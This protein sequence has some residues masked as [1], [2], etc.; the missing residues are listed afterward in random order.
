MVTKLVAPSLTHR[1][2]VCLATQ[3][4]LKPYAIMNLVRSL[5]AYSFYMIVLLAAFPWRLSAQA[6]KY[7]GMTVVNIRFEPQQQP[8]EG[9]ELF[10]I[11]PL[12]RGEPLR[13][14][15]V[16]AS[17]ERLFATGRYADIK[18]A[19]EPYNGGG[20]IVTFITTNS[21]FIGDVSVSGRV[22]DPPNRGQLVNATR[23]DLGE[24]YTGNALD[25]AIAAQK[26]LLE[27]NGL[28]LSSVSPTFDYD[29]EHQLINIRFRIDSG[30][31]ARFYRPV[32]L[33]NYKLDPARILTATRFRRW[34]IHTWKPVTQTRMRQGLDGVRSLYQK[35]NRLEAKVQL[36]SV[37]FDPATMRLVPTLNIDA[38][39]RI[40]VSTVGAK[41]SQ[42]KL[43]R[44]VP[45]FEEH[46]VDQDLLLEGAR[47]LRDYYQSQ[48]YFEAQ[49][50]VVPQKVV[51]DKSDV[52][53]PGQYREA[54]QAGVNRD[55]GQ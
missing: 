19:A 3:L 55:Q 20:V 30:P 54:A 29:T 52:D 40:E 24:P 47:N 16:R 27:G 7:E 21:W 44:Y 15:V 11:L 12:R 8:L 26:R 45:I 14:S 35:E 18:V 6:Q 28:Y 37:K 48:G 36:E 5:L 23:L 46:A 25:V 9:S 17:I 34:L 42:S 33:G 10:E 2:N 32:L 38:G 31:R 13:S 1:V 53:L 39:P 22:S 49:V 50:E 43:R 4:P 51:N 41:L